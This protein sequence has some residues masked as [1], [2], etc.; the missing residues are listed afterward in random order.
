MSANVNTSCRG[1]NDIAQMGQ[2]APAPI[3]RAFAFILGWVGGKTLGTN[4][5]G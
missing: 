3:D 2:I 4:T 1:R 5:V